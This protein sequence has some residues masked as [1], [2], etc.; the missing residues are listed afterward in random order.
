MPF[1]SSHGI[2]LTFG[3]EPPAGTQ[4]D[5][6]GISWSGC[7]INEIDITSMSSVVVQDPGNTNKKIIQQD[8]DHSVKS[9]GKITCEFFG[10]ALPDNLVGTTKLLA[11]SGGNFPTSWQATCEEINAEATVGDL[12]KGTVVFRL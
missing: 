9:F 1:T 7:S 3:G 4:F 2:T 8:L 6:I 10:A 11:I 5:V 12:V